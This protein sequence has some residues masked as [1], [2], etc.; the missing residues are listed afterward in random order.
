MPWCYTIKM[1][2]NIEHLGKS[3]AVQ[4]LGLGV[5]IAVGPG[6]IPGRGTKIPQAMQRGQKK[7]KKLNTYNVL[8]TV[9]STLHVLIHLILTITL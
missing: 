6:S 7:K 2:Y 9:L 8:R 4:L 3:L 1:V 5:F